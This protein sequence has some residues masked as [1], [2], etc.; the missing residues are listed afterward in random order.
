MLIALKSSFVELFKIL[1]LSV[2]E[3]GIYP[4][5]L[6][7]EAISYSEVFGC[8][9]VAFGSTVLACGKR[10]VSRKDLLYDRGN[11][12]LSELAKYFTHYQSW[13]SYCVTS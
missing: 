1:L 9:K 5:E 6:M 3:S 13:G 2:G 7:C 10:S 4:N 12:F 8:V 11:T